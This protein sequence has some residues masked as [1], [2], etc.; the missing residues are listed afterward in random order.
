MP[1]LFVVFSVVCGVFGQLFMKKGMMLLGPM[2]GSAILIFFSM[3]FQ[4]W[5][6]AGLALYGVAMVT[7]VAV[8]AK[9]EL[10]Y[11]YPLLASGYVLVALGSWW[12][13]GDVISLMRWA[14]IVCVSC[15]VALAAKK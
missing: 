7:W 10:G 13:F 11:A 15:G 9:L 1:Y 6:F 3:I 4:P 8:L 2:E 12:M 5:V 14:G